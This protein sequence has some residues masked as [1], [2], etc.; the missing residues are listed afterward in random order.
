M[1]EV[2]LSRKDK[3]KLE[4]TELIA[5]ISARLSEEITIQDN[6]KNKQMK[7]FLSKIL[8]DL[9]KVQ[10]HINKLHTEKKAKDP[11]APK[12]TIHQK[13]VIV[14]DELAYVC[15]WDDVTSHSYND[16][17]KNVW[18]YIREHGNDDRTLRRKLGIPSDVKITVKNLYSYI[19]PHIKS[20]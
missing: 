8:K 16:V 17:T 4:S 15:G 11:N 9:T 13:N 6:A 2:K 10:N 7:M 20:E 14:S 5:D 19:K 12:R 3:H 18:A 1:E